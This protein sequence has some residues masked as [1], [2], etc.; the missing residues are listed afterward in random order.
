VFD[1]GKAEPVANT[2]DDRFAAPER[3]FELVLPIIE[4]DGLVDRLDL[5]RESIEL[6]DVINGELIP[7]ADFDDL[8]IGGRGRDGGDA[9]ERHSEQN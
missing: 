2:V 5:T 3:D 9:E 8:P 6:R 1:H 4:P 7:P